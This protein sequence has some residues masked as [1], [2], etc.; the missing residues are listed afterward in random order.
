MQD[1][2]NAIALLPEKY[3]EALMNISPER[4]RE[5]KEIRFRVGEAVTLNTKDHIFYISSSGRITTSYTD[6]VVMTD[7]RALQ[8]IV[9]ML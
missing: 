5:I 4:C 8:E 7:E 1:F 2:I 6:N 9:F 3:K